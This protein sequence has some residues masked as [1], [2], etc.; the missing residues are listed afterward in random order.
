MSKE[1]LQLSFRIYNY[2]SKIEERLDA[3]F[4]THQ[5]GNRDLG[6]YYNL[7]DYALKEVTLTEQEALFI[8]D[9]TN[10]SIFDEVGIRMLWAGLEDSIRYDSLDAK[11]QIDGNELINK[12]KK[13]NIA[14]LFA[15]AD[16]IERFWIL[17]N[18]ETEMIDN[19]KKV[20]I[21]R[22]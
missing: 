7:L 10:G 4:T 2:K 19:L 17:N 21:L 16:A 6:R 13:A 22:K 8:V 5:I 20:G 12:I 3:S 1:N 14:Y 9:S 15:L 11:Y 18:S